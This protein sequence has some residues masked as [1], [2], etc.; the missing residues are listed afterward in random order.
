MGLILDTSVLIASERRGGAIED[1]LR[2][3][4]LVYGEI[5]IALS[6]SASWS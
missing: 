2:Q 3:A 5:D 4:R 6:V 1:I